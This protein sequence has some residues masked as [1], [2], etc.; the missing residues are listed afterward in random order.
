M[1]IK[2]LDSKKPIQQDLRHRGYRRTLKRIAQSWQLY[3]LILPAFVY[4]FMFM[5]MPMYGIQ[6]AFKQFSSKAGIWG[7]KWVGMKHFIRFTN[8]PYFGNIVRNTVMLS[9][10]SLIA[11]PVPI[12]FALLINEIRNTRFKKTVQMVT[13]APHFI[14]TVVLC[15]MVTL[16]L[17]K[18]D[19]VINKLIALLGG[20]PQQFMADPGAFPWIYVLSG[21][22]QGMGWG[23]ILYLA[24]LAGV[25]PELDE[26]AYLDGA[27]R[28]QIIWHINIP[29]ILPTI[30]I[31]FILE[32]GSIM[33]IG[34]E[35]VY[36]L[37]NSL[38]LDT[39]QVIST[40]VYEMGLR[41][42]KLDYSAAISLFNTVINIVLMLS[43]NLISKKVSDIS[44][45]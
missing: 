31:K 37:Q 40:Y 23:A 34:F 6:I 7:S 27:N 45:L 10:Y 1:S 22:W 12:I 4:A 3:V 41:S 33:S 2:V 20:T 17:S 21:L 25:S 11:F 19:G 13:Y 38:N 30:I 39:S 14:S 16:F 36:L 24:A 15:S 43:V 18:S 5:Y 8:D 32:F 28:F 44:V 9:L 26:A 35:K 42:G 29:T